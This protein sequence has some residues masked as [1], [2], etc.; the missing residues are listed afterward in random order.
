M[1]YELWIHLST[2]SVCLAPDIGEFKVFN[3]AAK[4]EMS[5]R[6]FHLRGVAQIDAKTL[7][8]RCALFGRDAQSALYTSTLRTVSPG[9]KHCEGKV[10]EQ[11]PHFAVTCV[12]RTTHH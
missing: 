7:R 6:G 11:L 5:N 3:L 12:S 2:H 8:T 4:F 9:N 1:S 10:M